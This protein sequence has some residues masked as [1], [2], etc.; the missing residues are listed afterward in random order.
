MLYILL[1]P[2][3]SGKGTQAKILSEK[4]HLHN[5]GMGDLIRDE[6]K[7][8]TDMGKRFVKFESEGALVPNELTNILIKEKFKSIGVNENYVIDGYPRSIPQLPGIE[9]YIQKKDVVVFNII[10]EPESIAKRLSKRLICEQCGKIFIQEENK[11]ISNC[12]KCGGKLIKRNDDSN[13]KSVEKRIDTY[14]NST[15]AVIDYFRTNGLLVDINGEPSIEEVSKEIW[16]K[17]NAR[18][19]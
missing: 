3:G 14:N 7:K 1:G 17:L 2:P 13:I 19:N 6:I 8:N 15:K 5:L 9:E 12:D 4:L 11:E 10:I 16:N 18:K